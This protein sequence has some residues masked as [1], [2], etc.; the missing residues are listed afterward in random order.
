MDLPRSLKISLGQL[1]G[2][3]AAGVVMHPLVRSGSLTRCDLLFSWAKCQRISSGL[4]FPAVLLRG[5]I[6]DDLRL[7]GAEQAKGR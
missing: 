4:W 2:K 3:E 6:G 7:W 1:Q 5:V